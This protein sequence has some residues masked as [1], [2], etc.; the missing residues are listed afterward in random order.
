MPEQSA[1]R[2][3]NGAVP[4]TKSTP[5]SSEKKARKTQAESRKRAGPDGPD[6]KVVGDTFKRKPTST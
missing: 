4:V 6:A 2:T 5:D 1:G 3:Q